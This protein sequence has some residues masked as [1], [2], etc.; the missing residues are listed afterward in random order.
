MRQAVGLL[1][2]VQFGQPKRS[3][4]ISQVPEVPGCEWSALLWLVDWC[5][6]EGSAAL[7]LSHNDNLMLRL[8]YVYSC[9]RNICV[10]IMA[11]CA[12]RWRQCARES[13]NKARVRRISRLAHSKLDWW[14]LRKAVVVM[15]MKLNWWPSLVKEQRT[16]RRVHKFAW[17]FRPCLLISWIP[18]CRY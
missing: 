8:T 1:G 17:Y 10:G 15:L 13:G 18:S 4:I 14:V 11:F 5:D 3:F 2:P 7:A 9:W 6:V 16:L 12:C